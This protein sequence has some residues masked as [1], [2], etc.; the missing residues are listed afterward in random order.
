MPD[1]P[2]VHSEEY[3]QYKENEKKIEAISDKIISIFIEEC[4]D[5]SDARSCTR[6][7]EEKIGNWVSRAKITS[8]FPEE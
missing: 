7:V 1:L 3:L 6:L 4:F 5:I 2:Y 8:I